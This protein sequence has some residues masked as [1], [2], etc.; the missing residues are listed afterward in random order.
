MDPAL[1]SRLRFE[2]GLPARHGVLCGRSRMGSGIRIHVGY[3]R[4]V[5]RDAGLRG[6]AMSEASLVRLTLD[7]SP[8]DGSA[9]ILV[10][11]IGMPSAT[12]PPVRHG[13]TGRRRALVEALARRFGA[14]AGEP[15]P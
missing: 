11:F 13:P 14:P 2:P 4:P 7:L 12:R 10:G 9:G 8:D 15:I 6:Q 5:W 3:P 1:V